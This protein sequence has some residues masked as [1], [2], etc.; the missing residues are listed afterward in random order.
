VRVPAPPQDVAAPDPTLAVP[1]LQ[2]LL[3][4]YDAIA[5]SLAADK[6]DGVAAAAAVVAE[7]A[8]DAATR[9]AAKTLAGIGDIEPARKQFLA[10]SDAV[11]A[12]A[13]ANHDALARALGDALPR[14]AHCPM[15]PGTWLQR[16]DDIVNPYYG[17][18][19]LHCGTFQSW[20]PQ[21]KN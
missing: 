3:D 17:S 5:V 11:I 8:P 21:A 6:L 13:T 20:D 7:N 9:T 19:M 10:L 4:A 18:K 12:Y 15:Y 14:K 16:G 1:A 2:R